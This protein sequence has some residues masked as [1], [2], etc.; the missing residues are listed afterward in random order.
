MARSRGLVLT[1]VLM[2]PCICLV[3]RPAG[4][5]TP[6][7][8]SWYG[9]L[10]ESNL[11]VN[12]FGQ[13]ISGTTTSQ[14]ATMTIEFDYLPG[15]T[16]ATLSFNGVAFNEFSVD[17]FGPTSADGSYYFSYGPVVAFGN[18]DVSYQSILPDGAIDTNG[19]FAVMDFTS[20]SS[21]SYPLSEELVTFQTV[22]EPSALVQSAIGTIV[23]AAFAGIQTWRARKAGARSSQ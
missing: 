22:P 21:I 15:P 23:I 14:Y 4:A 18:Y 13:V 20:V 11:Q 5:Q 8:G 17:G 16:Q 1:T 12:D 7:M 10:T 19:G 3:A 6:A 2:L 9:V